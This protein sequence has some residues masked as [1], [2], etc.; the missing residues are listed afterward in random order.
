MLFCKKY[1]IFCLVIILSKP[2]LRALAVPHR[3]W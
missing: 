1:Y 3:V 2:G